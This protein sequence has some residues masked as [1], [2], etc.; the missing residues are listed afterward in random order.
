METREAPSTSV[1]TE[2]QKEADRK[3]HWKQVE[4]NEKRLL[5]QRRLVERVLGRQVYP[6]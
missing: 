1:Q 3:K 6:R 4:A 5:A 2:I